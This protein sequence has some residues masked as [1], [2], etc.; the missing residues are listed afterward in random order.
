MR[1]I[2]R[3]SV[4]V[5]H[6]RKRRGSS[7]GIWKIEE[8]K[9]RKEKSGEMN[10]NIFEAGYPHYSLKGCPMPARQ[11]K[12][13]CSIWYLIP[14]SLGVERANRVVSVTN[15]TAIL[16]VFSLYMI[17]RWKRNSLEP[18]WTLKSDRKSWEKLMIGSRLDAQ[19][20]WR[21]DFWFHVTVTGWPRPV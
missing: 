18:D 14:S 16:W 11:G 17:G 9:G 13:Q 1:P 10:N 7:R 20:A 5:V 8:G 12:G 4:E 19:A 3:W 6:S 15:Y 2:S 21:I